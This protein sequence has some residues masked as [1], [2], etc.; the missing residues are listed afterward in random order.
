MSVGEGSDKF[1][2]T[3]VKGLGQ[4]ASHH[5]GWV[6]TMWNEQTD[7]NEDLESRMRCLEKKAGRAAGFWACAGSLLGTGILA[8]ILKATGVL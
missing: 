6:K 2:T 5:D 8:A 3:T 7:F 4:W 1:D